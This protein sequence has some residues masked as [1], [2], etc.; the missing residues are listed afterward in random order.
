[1]LFNSYAFI[2]AF[3]PVTLG[4]YFWLGRRREGRYANAWLALASLFFYGY[5]N[6]RY[7][8]LLLVSICVNYW[9]AGRIIAAQALAGRRAGGRW[10]ALGLAF[11]LG[12]LCWFKY[13]DFLIGTLDKLGA[14]LP[15]LHI[16]LPLGISFFSITQLV[17]LI[18]AYFYGE[19]HKH[20]NF[21]DYALFVSFFPH[22]LAGP[23]LYH[24]P[25]MK[26]FADTGLKVPRAESFARGIA[27]FTLGLGKKVLIADACIAPVAAGYGAA[28]AG[29][30]TFWGGWALALS[31]A[32]QLYFDFSG[33]SDM[34]VGAAKML[35]IDI[36]VNFRAPFRATSLSDFWSRWHI[37]LTQTIMAYIYT[38][39]VRLQRAGRSLAGAAGAT[40]LTML[41]IGI[42]HGAGWTYVLFGL[43]HGVALS[44]NQAWK[45]WHLP[46]PRPLA[47]CL[48][49]GFVIASCV[50]FRA[51]SV[52]QALAVYR[53]MFGLGG[54]LH[55]PWEHGA[56]HLTLFFTQQPFI[57]LPEPWVLL[58][59]LALAAFAPESHE[60]VRKYFR[61]S[62]SWALALG[63]IFAFSVLHFTQVTAFLYFQ[64]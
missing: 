20:R 30:L 50:L 59:A 48:T 62:L 6:V 54:G 22:L 3:L 25:M 5:W 21:V 63:L 38:P 2:F 13:M 26:Q 40:V 17:Y 24:K 31:Y 52:T 35:N 15:L 61:P 11:D 60:L 55:F 56:D 10:F 37:S 44:V 58:T 53:A 4:I 64:F 51:D 45:Q 47:R 16:V 14:G 49:M 19:G 8:P 57:F 42:W 32:L 7:L 28:D 1:M 46:M 29:T 41:L 18:G 12:L 27:L 39:L 9:L 43:L 36:P 23:I 33:Y 34:A